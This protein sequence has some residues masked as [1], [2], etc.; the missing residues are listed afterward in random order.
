MSIKM[1]VGGGEGVRYERTKHRAIFAGGVYHV[2]QRAPGDEVLFHENKDYLVFQRFLSR[3]SKKFGVTFFCFS[4]LPN[5]VHLLLQLAEKNLSESMKHLFESYA[6]FFNKNYKRKGH[7]FSGNFRAMVCDSDSY[8]LAATVYIHLNAFKAGLCKTFDAYRWHSLNAYLSSFENDKLVKSSFVL[9]KLNED[10]NLACQEYQKIMMATAGY[11]VVI[12]RGVRD[13]PWA[14][15]SYKRFLAGAQ[16]GTSSGSLPL[17]TRITPLGK[18]IYGMNRLL[19]LRNRGCS[20]ESIQNELGISKATYFRLLKRIN[21][22]NLS[23]E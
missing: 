14:V 8:L 16:N 13:I 10:R 22:A 20:R 11:P 19:E 4:L 7:V 9:S 6:K 23:L 1:R 15:N 3:T 12:G 21:D 2:I 5:H 18:A 17:K